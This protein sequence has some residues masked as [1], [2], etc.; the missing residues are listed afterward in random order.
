VNAAL[1]IISHSPCCV[2]VLASISRIPPRA[3]AVYGS[4]SD[5]AALARTVG[6]NDA[7]EFANGFEKLYLND[8]QHRSK[9]IKEK[10]AEKPIADAEKDKQCVPQSGA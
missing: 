2:T 1:P 7:F 10:G 9:Y 3:S 5:P 6:P 4:H 8:E